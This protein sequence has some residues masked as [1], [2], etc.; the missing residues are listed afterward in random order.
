MAKKI[1]LFAFVLMFVGS[2]AYAAPD[3]TGKWD[4]GVDVSGAIPTD[5]DIDA[6]VQVSGS[7]DYGVSQWLALGFEGADAR[8]SREA[9]QAGMPSD[10]YQRRARLRQSLT[11]ATAASHLFM[12]A[13]AMASIG[14]GLGAIGGPV[15]LVVGVA[16]ALGAA[17]YFGVQ[18]SKAEKAILDAQP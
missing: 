2:L 11:P 17:L 15:G 5:N 16:G 14:I 18:G 4:V 7:V 8:G 3:R 6:G 9:L 12:G 1:A 10:A 13:G